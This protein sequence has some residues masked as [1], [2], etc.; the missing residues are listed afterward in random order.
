FLLYEPELMVGEGARADFP[1][2][3]E[4]WSKYRVVILGDVLPGQLTPDRQKVV[5]EYVASAGGTL[6]VIAGKNA[7][8]AAY[9]DQPL[10]ALL[11]VEAGDRAL[12][13]DR[14]FHLHVTDEG[15]MS[16]AT[17]LT[18]EPGASERIW[19]E[20]SEKLPLYGLSE[21]SKP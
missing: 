9:Y 14:G 4:E 18:D 16:L 2:T 11:P 21:H 7:M 15:S 3:V 12:P 5:R 6:V 17:Q 8:P 13:P 10:G 20:M 1:S 19:R